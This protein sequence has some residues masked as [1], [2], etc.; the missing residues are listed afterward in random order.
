MGK[1][2]DRQLIE[3]F[4][5]AFVVERRAARNSVLAYRRDL[6]DFLAHVGVSFRKAQAADLH[7]Y[8]RSLDA[9]GLKASTVARRLSALRRFFLFLL[10]EGE[11][12]DNPMTGIESP[13]IH[14]PLPAVLDEEAVSRLLE[15]AA[16]RLA[17]REQVGA[18]LSSQLEAARDLALVELL[19]ATGM[20]I[21]EVLS[22]KRTAVHPDR[23]LLLVKGKGGRERVIPVG[24]AARTAL[25]YYLDL[26]KACERGG[27][28]PSSWLFPGRPSER[29]L[30][31][32]RAHEILKSLAR[33]AGLDPRAVSAHKLRHAFATHLLAHGADLRVLQQ[34]LGHADLSTTQ[35]Y[36]HV[37]DARLRAL[38]E[39]K[40]PLAQGLLGEN[41]AKAGRSKST[42][43]E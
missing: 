42:A 21:S 4:L 19:Y 10:E 31:R 33:E 37:L 38:V 17:R 13:R 16:D 26:R 28:P 15:V 34:M 7:R 30:G 27:S 43:G 11:R 9:R 41:K 29:P 14:R 36:T 2:D 35:I 32:M 20:R 6:E 8:L 39:E 1:G 23:P 5:E 18:P 12:P 25:A 24:E 3:R 22:L 40:H